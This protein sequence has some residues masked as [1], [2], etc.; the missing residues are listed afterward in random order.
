MLA[1]PDSV[2]VVQNRHM[3]ELPVTLMLVP[4]QNGPS[5]PNVLRSVAV[6]TSPAQD[7]ATVMN[8]QLEETSRPCSAISKLVNG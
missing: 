1:M 7:N 4:C 6:E 2:D 5:G 8:A 3:S